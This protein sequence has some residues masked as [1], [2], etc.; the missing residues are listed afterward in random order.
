MNRVVSRRNTIKASLCAFIALTGCIQQH[1]DIPHLTFANYRSSAVAVS[2]SVKAVDTGAEV[3][4]K[5]FELTASNIEEDSDS[6][7]FDDLE[8][9][10]EYNISVTVNGDPGQVSAS[11][12]FNSSGSSSGLTIDIED[13]EIDFGVRGA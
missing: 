5:E 3:L 1:A 8:Y 6:R 10:T 2:F 7:T 4:S 13:D 11:H 12:R 9:E